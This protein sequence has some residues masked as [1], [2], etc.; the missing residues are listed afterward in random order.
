MLHGQA[1]SQEGGA[2]GTTG[3]KKRLRTK[4]GGAFQDTPA[5][6]EAG[7]G[8]DIWRRGSVTARA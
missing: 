2:S 1:P 7:S 8:C 5:G 4:S 6:L 3:I